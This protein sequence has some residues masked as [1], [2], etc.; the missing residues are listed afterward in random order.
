MG[1]LFGAC[2]AYPGTF[3]REHQLVGGESPDRL[4]HARRSAGTF[5][6][7]VTPACACA[8][9][10]PCAVDCRRYIV[11]GKYRADRSM[12][13]IDERNFEFDSRKTDETAGRNGGDSWARR[14]DND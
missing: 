2:D 9:N 3:A 13:R 1:G 8:R 10:R 5:I 7:R 14:F 4:A 12:G 11:S 6:L